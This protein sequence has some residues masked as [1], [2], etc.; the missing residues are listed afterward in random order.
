MKIID[1]K[2]RLFGRINI[3]D[4]IILVFI[5]GLILSSVYSYKILGKRPSAVKPK[6][7]NVEVVSFVI[8]EIATLIKEGDKSFDPEGNIDGVVLKILQKNE[9]FSDRLKKSMVSRKDK[10]YEYRIPIFLKL[11]L[12]CT[13]DGKNQ[14]YYYQRSPIFVEANTGFIFDT[15]KYKIACYAIK[16]SENG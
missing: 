11:R 15:N 7:V 8:P 4:F 1:S 9:E 3:I 13:K 16:F 12:A 14:P 2:G 5:I 6:W 10:M